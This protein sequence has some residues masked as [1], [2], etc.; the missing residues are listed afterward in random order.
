[1]VVPFDSGQLIAGET[2]VPVEYVI[3]ADDVDDAAVFETV[4]PA[5]AVEYSVAKVVTL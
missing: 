2:T 5:V 3:A 4:A 1:M